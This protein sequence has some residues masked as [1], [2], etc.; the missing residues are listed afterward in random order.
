M[1]LFTKRD[2]IAIAFIAALI[3]TGWGLKFAVHRSQETENLRI[4]RNAVK[5]PLAH[6]SI[7]TLTVA[8]PDIYSPVDINNADTGELENLPMIG[9]VKAAAIIEYRKKHGFFTDIADIMKV[10][11]IGP[12]TYEKIRNQITVKS[13]NGLKE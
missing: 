2:R 3:L 9:P 4:I 7:D 8:F 5:L 11:G 10:K 13:N 1:A 12:A 6:E